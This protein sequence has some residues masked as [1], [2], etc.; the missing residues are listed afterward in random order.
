MPVAHLPRV[1]A[2]LLAAGESRRMGFPKALLDLAGKTFLEHILATFRRVPF[3]SVT[4]VLG[5]E[6]DRIR[7]SCRIT[8]EVAC[9]VN[10]EYKLGQLSS[11][12]AGLRRCDSRAVDG[13]LVALVDHPLVTSC[14]MR[15]LMRVLGRNPESIVV[16]V[17]EGR[18][19]HPVLF[20]ASYYDDLLEAPLEDGARSVVH[21]HAEKVV[22]WP[23][24]DP[25]VLRDIDTPELYRALGDKP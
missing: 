21:R 22:Q 20:A 2:I 11:L 17:F 15:A 1:D 5:A 13:F 6:A 10:E 7:Q 19:G 9:V 18:R 4:I 24:R 8:P 25:G 12:Q 14:S 16:P 3:R 23:V